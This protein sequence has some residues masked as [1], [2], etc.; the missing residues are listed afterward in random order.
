MIEREINSSRDC[1]FAFYV[2]SLLFFFWVPFFVWCF[3]YIISSATRI[4][5][6][7]YDDARTML[8]QSVGAAM[9]PA[10]S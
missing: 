5:F 3:S 1:F 10:H 7:V 6:Y 9:R 4:Y 8:Q 2:L